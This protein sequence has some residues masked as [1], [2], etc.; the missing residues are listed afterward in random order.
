MDHKSLTVCQYL[1]TKSFVDFIVLCGAYSVSRL[2]TTIGAQSEER[3]GMNLVLIVK[4]NNVHCW[5]Q[6]ISIVWFSIFI[7]F[8]N[9]KCDNSR[10]SACWENSN[11][12][13][14]IL[15]QELN[16]VYNLKQEQ[17]I[18]SQ[19]SHLIHNLQ[20]TVSATDHH[21]ESAQAGDTSALHQTYFEV[22]KDCRRRPSY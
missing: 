14:F 1:S 17:E 4:M 20:N 19:Q 3:V 11:E 15:F 16:A 22:S 21:F 7:D 9:L 10:G 12:T 13:F 6:W 2:Q 5:Q 8:L 18:Q